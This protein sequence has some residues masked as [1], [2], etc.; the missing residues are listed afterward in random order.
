MIL[1]DDLVNRSWPHSY[2]E[3]YFCVTGAAERPA[4]R[5]YRFAQRIAE[6]V[7]IHPADATPR[8]RRFW[9][10]PTAAKCRFVLDFCL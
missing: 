6:E 7:G 9:R 3:R 10:R 1:A 2:R 4:G 5:R 8:H